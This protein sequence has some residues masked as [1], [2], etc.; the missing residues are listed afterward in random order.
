[1]SEHEAIERALS[2]LSC[3]Y[4]RAPVKARPD[5]YVSWFEVLAQSAL[6]ASNSTRR[7]EHMMQVDIYSRGATDALLDTVLRLLRGGGFKVAS[8][9]PEDY[10]DDTRYRHVPITVRI[11]TAIDSED[12]QEQE[13][14]ENADQ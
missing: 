7:M 10:E 11:N 8:Y 6:D 1:M 12:K 4:G 14:E 9:G 3:P 5:T 13:E 2:P